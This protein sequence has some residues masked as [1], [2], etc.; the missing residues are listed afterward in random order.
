MSPSGCENAKN[1]KDIPSKPVG[2][3]IG[4]C[5]KNENKY[6]ILRDGW[7]SV[8]VP[9]IMYGVEVKTRNVSEA[10][11]LAVGPNRVVRIAINAPKYIAIK[12][13]WG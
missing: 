8:A 12:A 11:I 5:N 6:D 10:D 9:S 3:T 2:R 4:K 7:R 1:E 13:V